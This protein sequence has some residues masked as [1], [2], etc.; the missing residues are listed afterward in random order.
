MNN[1]HV[2][3]RPR[4]CPVG[5]SIADLVQALGLGQ[6]RLAVEHNGAIVSR[7]TWMTTRIE[8]GDRLEIVGAVGGG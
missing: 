1:I 2:N 3:G 6:Q 8:D 4:Q 5:S 7:S